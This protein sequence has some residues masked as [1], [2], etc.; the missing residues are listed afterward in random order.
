MTAHAGL[1]STP[2]RLDRSENGQLTMG[3]L[4]DEVALT[5][6]GVTR[7]IDRM[8]KTGHAELHPRTTDR[9]ISFAAITD[10]GRE[11]L[12]RAAVGHGRSLRE[13]RRLQRRGPD[14]AGRPPRPPRKRTAEGL[15]C[16]IR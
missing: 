11:I 2:I 14:H 7:L 1:R 9:R 5:T 12:D 4:A 6:G 16:R 10:R 8:Q 13:L 3:A 15:D